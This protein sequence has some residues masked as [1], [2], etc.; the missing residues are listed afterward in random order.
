V[1]LFSNAKLNTRERLVILLLGLSVTRNNLLPTGDADTPTSRA[2]PIICGFHYK[3]HDTTESNWFPLY[4]NNEIHITLAERKSLVFTMHIPE[5][6]HS[7]FIGVIII[8]ITQRLPTNMPI[9]KIHSPL[10]IY[11]RLPGEY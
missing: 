5:I 7:Y 11:I 10:N 9:A 2:F 3:N 4:L 8:I 6:V 1:I